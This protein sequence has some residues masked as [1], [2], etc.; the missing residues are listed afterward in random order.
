MAGE[1]FNADMLK[2]AR[3]ARELTQSELAQKSGITQ[4]FISKLEH[5]LNSFNVIRRLDFPIFIFER[6]RSLVQSN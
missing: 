5:G 2:L 4:A 6:E 1:V 3:D